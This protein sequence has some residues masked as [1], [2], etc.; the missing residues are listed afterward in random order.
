MLTSALTAVLHNHIYEWFKVAGSESQWT[1]TN[2]IESSGL[3]TMVE[4]AKDYICWFT[5]MQRYVQSQVMIP[6]CYSRKIWKAIWDVIEA[7]TKGCLGVYCSKWAI[8]KIGF[9]II[10]METSTVLRT[11]CSSELACVLYSII[12]HL[13]LTG[14]SMFLLKLQDFLFCDAGD[15]KSRKISLW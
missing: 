8:D 9:V 11:T 4:K 1:N 7:Y 13:T 14:S 12:N 15:S 6:W 10:C 2:E 3:C 5:N